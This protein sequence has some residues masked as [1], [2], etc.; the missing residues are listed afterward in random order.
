MVVVHTPNG[1]TK[2]FRPKK[3]SEILEGLL[4]SG[5]GVLESI[6]QHPDGLSYTG[7]DEVPAGEYNLVLAGEWRH[8]QRRTGKPTI[9]WACVSC[10]EPP[11]FLLI[12]SV[13]CMQ[14]GVACFIVHLLAVAASHG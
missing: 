6:Q 12:G 9:C 11:G 5:R 13:C 8:A 1:Q 4:G 10:R 3:A 2:R 14:Q 7:S